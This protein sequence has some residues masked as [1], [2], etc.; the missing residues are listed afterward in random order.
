MID[1]TNVSFGTAASALK[2]IKEGSGSGLIP[3][4]G[5]PTNEHQRVT[6]P[7]GQ[8]TD[9]LL[10]RVMVSFPGYPAYS[11][12]FVIPFTVAGLY[13]TPSID[14]TNLYIEAGQSGVG[15]P[16]A[17]FLYYYRVFYP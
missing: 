8:S 4:T 12:H 17:V 1:Y 9:G 14:A 15:L 2:L 16:A 5:A 10:Y 6:I 7:H 13:A 11:D 3:A